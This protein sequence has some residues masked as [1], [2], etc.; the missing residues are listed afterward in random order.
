[1]FA[2]HAYY[3]HVM[4]GLIRCISDLRN[5]LED[6]RL[7]HLEEDQFAILKSAHRHMSLNVHMVHAQYHNGYFP[8]NPTIAHDSSW[9]DSLG[10]T[11]APASV[12]PYVWRE[13]YKRLHTN[14]LRIPTV[15]II[16]I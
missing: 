8:C 14:P 4:E 15:V 6:V 10:P 16:N 7:S 9:L 1:M 5:A 12:F 13:G 2:A 11:L 3:F